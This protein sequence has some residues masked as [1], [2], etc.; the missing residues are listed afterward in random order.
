MMTAERSP[1]LRSRISCAAD[2]VADGPPV[3]VSD[4]ARITGFSGEKILQDIYRGELAAH[5]QRR[6]SSPYL[7]ARH[8]ASRYLR[9]L[10]F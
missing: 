6:P 3:R 7:I 1:A 4:L 2:L 8:E 10:G 5:R 9:A